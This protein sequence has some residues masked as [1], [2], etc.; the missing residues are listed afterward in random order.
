MKKKKSS[1]ILV[2]SFLQKIFFPE[3]KEKSYFYEDKLSGQFKG[4]ISN[5]KWD[6]LPKI[7]WIYRSK[8]ADSTNKLV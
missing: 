5:Q 2:G 1:D 6:K 8:K 4:W 3:M 7:L